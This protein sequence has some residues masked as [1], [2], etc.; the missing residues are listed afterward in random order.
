[1]KKLLPFTLTIIA[2]AV[3]SSCGIHPGYVSD[4][5]CLSSNNFEYVKQNVKAEEKF[6]QILGFGGGNKKAIE[7]KAKENLVR[8]AKLEDGQALANMSVSYH[9]MNL[10]F[11]YKLTCTVSADIVEFTDG[12]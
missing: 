6:T 1:M 3:F 10:G 7:A 8:R 2:A 4:S 12:K 11:Y 9:I 5:A